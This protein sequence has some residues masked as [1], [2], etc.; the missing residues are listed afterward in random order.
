MLKSNKKIKNI[1]IVFLSI[2][3]VLGT[4]AG[5]G[6]NS[7]TQA[8]VEVQSETSDEG[9]NTETTEIEST[10]DDD[11]KDENNVSKDENVADSNAEDMTST[12]SSEDKESG[13][14]NELEIEFTAV[15]ETVYATTTVNIRSQASVDSDVVSLLNKRASV[16]RIGV[17]DEWSK[18]I[19]EGRECYIATEY[20]TTEEPAAGGH[21]IA[22]DAGHQEKGNSEHEPIGPGSSST[23]PKVASGTTG[24]T[25]GVPEYK[26]TLD[27]SLKLRDELEARGYEVIMIR[28]SHDVNISNAERA[29]IANNAGVEAFIRVHANGSED[30]SVN[31]ILTMCQTASNPYNSSLYSQSRSLSEKVLS[32]LIASTRA[33]NK[34][35]IETDSMSGINW[36]QTPV[37]IVEMGF[38]SNP[39]ED[40]LMQTTDY[41]NKLVQGMAN[42]IDSYFGN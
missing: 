25:T 14:E 39:N 42:G 7:G 9:T 1:F 33:T 5:C 28:E 20:L 18:V 34:G 16:Q 38:M 32:G 24:T 29:Q 31:G 22:I 11:S 8:T 23:K 10:E 40:Q 41:Q 27:V 26:L 13:T 36:C 21:L 30:S 3:M 35:I 37:T 12:V 2:V 19:Y 6:K 4:L 15:D 17:S